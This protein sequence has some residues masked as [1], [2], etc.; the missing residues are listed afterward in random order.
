MAQDIGH[1]FEA[2]TVIDHL[3]GYRVTE[4]VAGDTRGDDEA[5][6]F[7]RLPHNGPDRSTGQGVK[8]CPTLQKDL[9]AFTLTDFRQPFKKWTFALNDYF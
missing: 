9:A 7:E 4:D 1:L 8:R 2:R 6:T 3:G 5:G